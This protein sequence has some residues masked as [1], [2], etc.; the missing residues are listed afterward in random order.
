MAILEP[1]ERRE[2]EVFLECLVFLDPLDGMDS[3]DRR[4]I[5][6]TLDC[7][8][9]EGLLERLDSLV[10]LELD[11]LD[12]RETPEILDHQGHP[13]D[14]EEPLIISP[15]P[16]D[17]MLDPREILERREKRETQEILEIVD[18]LDNPEIQECLECLE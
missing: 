8:D 11:R 10:I 16:R 6:E 17:P 3:L 15:L 9:L 2:M 1:L 5:E 13:G 18:S 14:R 7:L 4:E 12:P